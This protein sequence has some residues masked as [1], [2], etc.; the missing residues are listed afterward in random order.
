MKDKR[1]I[2]R[3]DMN[4]PFS[5]RGRIADT[6]RIKESLATIRWI[7]SRGGKVFVLLHRSRPRGFERKYSIAP[8]AARAAGLLRQPVKIVRNPIK[9]DPHA[10]RNYAVLFCENIRFFAG[11]EANTASFSRALARWGELFVNDA[12]AVSHRRSAS[13]VGLP[14][15]LPSYGGLLLLREVRALTAVFTRPRRPLLVILGGAKISTKIP[16]IAGLL[17]KADRVVLGGA[18]L[19]TVLAAK[20]LEV[21]RSLIEPAM[22]RESRKLLRQ[23][24]L[25][26]P[27]DVVVTKGPQRAGKRR[28]VAVGRI[29]E[30]DYILDIGSRGSGAIQR[31]IK[32]A[33]TILWNGPL[34]NVDLPGGEG[35]TL[36]LLRALLRARGNA[37]IGGGDLGALLKKIRTR[38]RRIYVSTGGGAT[39]EFVARGTLPG[40]EA[41]KK[42]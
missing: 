25:F 40:I 5:A 35:A 8:I 2:I 27:G 39:L 28:T 14:K 17:K 22:F 38:S 31:L 21:G 32:S 11:E 10:Y 16:Y 18:L 26:L 20:R 6:F 9:E 24:K 30:K 15:F 1:V 7:L 37:V 3:V 33:R 29:E 34:G 12:F 41:L 13:V 23:Q 36:I 4:V 42:T 19:N